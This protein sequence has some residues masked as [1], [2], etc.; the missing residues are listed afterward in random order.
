MA[1]AEG[2]SSEI[3]EL[4]TRD[5]QPDANSA[6][7]RALAA[8]AAKAAANATSSRESHR[9]DKTTF[10]EGDVKGVPKR[11]VEGRVIQQVRARFN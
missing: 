3:E 10:D 7:E 9:Y 1:P 6:A 11:K 4:R 2:F 5:I 8:A